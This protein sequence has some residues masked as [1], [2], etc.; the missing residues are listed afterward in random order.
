MISKGMGLREE[1]QARGQR[2]KFAGENPA[3]KP[4]TRHKTAGRGTS[5]SGISRVPLCPSP[6]SGKERARRRHTG[7]RA[8]GTRKAA[9]CCSR[10]R[11]PVRAKAALRPAPRPSPQDQQQPSSQRGHRARSAMPQ[12]PARAGFPFDSSAPPPRPV[13]SAAAQFEVCGP[14]D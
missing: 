12:P 8:V 1:I 14:A 9:A 7:R 4:Q 3:Q 2:K 10:L 13:C 6:D 5:R 11:G